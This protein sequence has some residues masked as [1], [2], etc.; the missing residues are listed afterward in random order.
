MSDRLRLAVLTTGRQ[1]WGLLR[2]LCTALLGDATFDLLLLAGGMACSKAFGQ[3]SAAMRAE[4]FEIAREMPWDVEDADA[5]AQAGEALRMTAS[6]LAGLQPDALVL[7][8]DRFE[9]AAAALAATIGGIP[10]VH[11][12]GG[13]ET[14]GAFDN[15]LRHA[16]TKMSHLHLVAHEEYARRVRQMGE[17]P[18]SVH[19]VGSLGVDNV[20]SQRRLSREQLEALLGIRLVPPVGVVTLH[21]STLGSVPPEQ[22]LS[23]VLGAMQA[24]PATWVVTLPN[25]DPGSEGIRSAFLAMASRRRNVVAVAALGSEAYLGLLDAADFILGN[26]SSGITEAPALGLPTINV[27]DRQRGRIRGASILDVSATP[28][29]VIGAIARSQ[30]PEFRRLAREAPAPYDGGDAAARIAAV[31]SCWRPPR[32][33]RKIFH[34]PAGN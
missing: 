25:A 4:G 24:C 26:S 18:A 21:P 14:E 5:S 27:G 19:V 11:L 9:T 30:T 10:I 7:L 15:S 33:P 2:P 34:A 13:E 3:V 31:L 28:E 1:D 17:D 22:E 32:P 20:R 12:Y 6:A 8:G 29:A 23:S 16:I